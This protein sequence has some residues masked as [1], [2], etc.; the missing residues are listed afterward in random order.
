M[1]KASMREMS[2]TLSG[3]AALTPLIGASAREIRRLPGS[4][5]RSV[6]LAVVERIG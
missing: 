4:M 3:D 6:E 1:R 5:P 2:L